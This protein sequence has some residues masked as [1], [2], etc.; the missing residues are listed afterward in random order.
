MSLEATARPEAASARWAALACEH[1]RMLEEVF[2]DIV[3]SVV[4]ACCGVYGDRLDAVVVFG[5]VARHRMRPD[6]DVDLLVVAEPLPF[7]RLAR[8]AEF[9]GVER[10]AAPAFDGASRQGVTTRLSPIVRTIGELRRSGFLLFD[11]ACDGEVH[12]DPGGTVAGYLAEVRS[13]L[14]ARGARRHSASGARC[15]VLDPTVGPA[16]VV[17]L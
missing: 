14:E 5:S 2:S 12:H 10:L 15:W 7:G 11:I 9:D 16:D 4:D 3:G 6:S 17:T 8:M 13:G 1:V